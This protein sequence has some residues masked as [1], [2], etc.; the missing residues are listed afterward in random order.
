MGQN[1]F[2]MEKPNNNQNNDSKLSK[3]NETVSN[4]SINHDKSTIE[5]Y[6]KSNYMFRYNLFTSAIEYKAI[7]DKKY[8]V[9][10]DYNLNSLVRELKFNKFKIGR[11][12]LD[13]L[14]KSNFT[15]E[16]HPL[17]E[18][19]T[20]LP[21][22]NKQTDHISLLAK[23]I[24]TDNDEFFADALKRWLV[25]LVATGLQDDIV[26]QSMIILSGGQGIGKSTFIRNLLPDDLKEYHYSGMINPNSKDTLIQLS[27]CLIIDLDELSNLTRK[28]NNEVKE[29]ITKSKIKVRRP[30]ARIPENLVRRASFIGSIN[31][32][33]FLTDLT[34]NRRYL[35]FK[36]KSID[37][38]TLVN[39]A[40]I[41]S[42]ALSL[43]RS[44]FK[45]YFDGAEIKKINERNENFRAKTPIEE[46]IMEYY[47]PSKDKSKAEL[48]LS[49]TEI[50]KRL[51]QNSNI[52]F[53]NTNS[54]QLGKILI[55]LGFE[56][57][58]RDG[59]YKYA[60]DINRHNCTE[61]QE[62]LKIAR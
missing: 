33:E 10:K 11:D 27:E 21:K 53:T 9:M 48:Y 32:H 47:K 20:T 44:G 29:L 2:V 41:F 59:V 30:Y 4:Q 14:F 13:N 31:E 50:L 8:R 42:Q 16:H 19:L 25:A 57:H 49:S 39:H 7:G 24:K 28:G 45:F 12:G 51:N 22:W 35:C 46:L 15:P 36:V 56:R 58:K 52:P 62:S 34:G 61:Q 43:Y 54:I 18:Y 40:G 55:N 37:N 17:K 6:L 3:L 23:S 1:Y 60:L 26:N 5:G 38:D